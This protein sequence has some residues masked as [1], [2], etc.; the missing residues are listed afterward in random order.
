MMT[1]STMRSPRARA[2]SAQASTAVVRAPAVTCVLRS[3]TTLSSQSCS[4][5][6]HGFRRGVV[7][8]GWRWR[9]LGFPSTPTSSA[10]TAL[11]RLRCENRASHS[12]TVSHRSCRC[13]RGACSS[14]AAA[15]RVSRAW[16]LAG[17][18]GCRSR[19]R[20]HQ[21]AQRRTAVDQQGKGN[22]VA[23]RAD[24]RA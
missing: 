10:I 20:A 12:S 21:A 19:G 22:R 4:P 15:L 11:D 9:L 23:D 1:R 7:G 14:I 18:H 24:E 17:S 6:R 16:T 3:L 13:R 5:R 2:A 8:P